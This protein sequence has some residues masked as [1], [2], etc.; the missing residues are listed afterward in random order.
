M[1]SIKKRI[2]SRYYVAT[3]LV[4]MD[5][6]LFRIAVYLKSSLSLENY[7]IHIHNNYINFLNR[8]TV[9]YTLD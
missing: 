8:Y 4:F 9:A 2:K 5:G 3:H 7:S 6:C 1:K